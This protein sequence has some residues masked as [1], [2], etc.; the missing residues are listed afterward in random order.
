LT[1]L[2]FDFPGASEDGKVFPDID[3]FFDAVAWE[4]SQ[5]TA[6]DAQRN[7]AVAINMDNLQ[8]TLDAMKGEDFFETFDKRNSCPLLW[9]FVRR[10]RWDIA[11][12]FPLCDIKHRTTE[13][14]VPYGQIILHTDNFVTV[15]VVAET[16]RIFQDDHCSDGS[17]FD[18]FVIIVI[19]A[20][21]TCRD[22]SQPM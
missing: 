20:L 22:L 8:G 15:R 12:R 4:R 16:P 3:K 21:T 10:H 17:Q 11:M 1:K 14:T 6:W 5:E 18:S 19:F 2:H 13:R 7:C 9:S